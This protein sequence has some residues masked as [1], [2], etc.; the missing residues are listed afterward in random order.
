MEMRRLNCNADRQTDRRTDGRKCYGYIEL[1]L[2]GLTS[3]GREGREG[4]GRERNGERMLK[5]NEKGMGGK[6]KGSRV[7]LFFNPTLTIVNCIF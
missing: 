1:Y 4:E 5:G 7:P 6:G 3:K 2:R